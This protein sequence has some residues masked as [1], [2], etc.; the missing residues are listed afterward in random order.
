MHENQNLRGVGSP[1]T[2][3]AC[4]LFLQNLLSVTTSHSPAALMS[5]L[6]SDTRPRSL[7]EGPDSCQGPGQC[8]GKRRGICTQ[9]YELEPSIIQAYN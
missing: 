8:E 9:L 3:M 6:R 1:E 5:V 4:E 2:V 7:R